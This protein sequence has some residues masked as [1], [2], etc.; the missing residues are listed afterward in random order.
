[1]KAD[2]SLTFG[3]VITSE[4]D[5]LLETFAS[6]SESIES[7]FI[8]LRLRIDELEKNV[9]GAINEDKEGQINNLREQLNIKD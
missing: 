5:R 7:N 8:S 9:I 3:G 1:M 2:F 6:N 4:V